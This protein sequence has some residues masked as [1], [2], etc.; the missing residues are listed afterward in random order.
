[1]ALR[2]DVYHRLGGVEAACLR[3]TW[4]DSDLCLKA[5]AA[6]LRVIVTPFARLVHVELATRGSELNA[7]ANA[8]YEAERAWM[9][10]RWG[11]RLDADPFHSPHLD[12]E[13]GDLRLADPKPGAG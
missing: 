6:G 7:A 10:Q 1:M 5:W 9:R 3:V 8:R 2:R 11:A 4:S 13:T 12:A